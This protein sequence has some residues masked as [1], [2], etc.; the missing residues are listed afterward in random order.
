MGVHDKGKDLSR[1]LGEKLFH[2]WN[3][4]SL[5]NILLLFSLWGAAGQGLPKAALQIGTCLCAYNLKE[6]VRKRRSGKF[7]KCACF[8][9]FCRVSSLWELG[10]DA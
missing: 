1:N 7:N 6:A 3:F 4:K 8:P 5:F 10:F 2:P 9:A